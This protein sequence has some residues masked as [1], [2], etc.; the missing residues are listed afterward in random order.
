M[1]F[2]V[3]RVVVS[4]RISDA[5]RKMTAEIIL[6]SLNVQMSPAPHLNLHVKTD[7]AYRIS[8]SAIQRTIVVTVQM[9]EISVQKKLVHISSLR[10]LEQVIVSLNHGC[11]TETMIAS[12]NK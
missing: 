1:N 2:N 3:N 4:H 11:V 8:G 6:M 10:A 5:I 7:V 9:K 12:I